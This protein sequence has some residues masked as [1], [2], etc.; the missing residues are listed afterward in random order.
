MLITF[1][2][3]TVEK[4]FV[5]RN[6]IK[7]VSL[8]SLIL[9]CISFII[10]MLLGRTYT[11]IYSLNNKDYNLILDNEDGEVEIINEEQKDDKYIVK[12][13]AKKPGKVFL[14]LNIDDIQ[15]VNILYVHKNM[16]ITD[17][18]F[19]GRST[20]SEVIPI[21]ISIVLLYILSLLIKKYRLCQKE[22]I[23]QYK[24]IAYVGIIIFVSFLTLN[25]IISI[26]NYKGLFE[27][28][29]KFISSILTVSYFLLPISLITFIFVT[30][31]NIYLI[32]KE[33]KSVRNLLGLFLGIFICI[34]T[35]LPE[36]LYRLLMESQKIDIYNLNSIGPYLYDFFE[37]VIYLI[38]TY[39]EC[40]LI[41]TIII[42][43]KS[44]KKEPVMNKDYIIILG[45]KI[46]KDNSLP[47]LL[48]GRVD[49]AIEF[50]NAQL[51][52]N[53][54]D[55]IFV[56]SSGKGDDETI[57]E[58][59][60]MKKYLIKQGIKEKN[61]L[62]ENKSRNTYE[63]IK[64]S[65]EIINNKDANIIF[66]TTNYHV[67]RAGLIATEQGLK[68]EGIGSKT[69]IYFW[70]NAFIREFIGT[71]YTERKKHLLFFLITIIIIIIMIAITYVGY[72]V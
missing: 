44:I 45:C 25:N 23:Y 72:N 65:N 2:I 13:K 52:A 56:P 24:N 41:A 12:V 18:N 54:K 4:V 6:S 26:F 15:E 10:I 32:K 59:E 35:V 70:L 39:L 69:K 48:K 57:T 7:K 33:G 51:K 46:K 27:T 60:A 66:S 1:D 62:I 38:V 5:M 28:I 43:I 34:L 11:V 16:V 21:S 19:F 42:A 40:V 37:T 71:L 20:G 68:I 31:S 47:P 30:I 67:L 36:Y 14:S 29:K 58:A 9:I 53:G 55:L 64:F 8:L 22:N 49:R 61:I 63:N 50:R 3:I 17:N